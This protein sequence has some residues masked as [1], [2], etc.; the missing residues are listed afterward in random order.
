MGHHGCAQ[1]IIPTTV[2]DAA[3]VKFVSVGPYP[4]GKSQH[5][6][7]DAELVP[8][9]NE[10]ITDRRECYECSYIAIATK[11]IN[12][13]DVL[14]VHMEDVDGIEA[15]D[16]WNFDLSGY[17]ME[18]THTQDPVNGTVLS[19]VS[20]LARKLPPKQPTAMF[21]VEACPVLNDDQA[22]DPETPVA[23]HH[24]F[25]MPKPIY[26]KEQSVIGDFRMPSDPWFDAQQSG[27][28]V[29]MARETY[30]NDTLM[31]HSTFIAKSRPEPSPAAAKAAAAALA[32]AAVTKVAA[33]A[34][35]P[36]PVLIDS[37]EEAPAPPKKLAGPRTPSPEPRPA[38]KKA[39]VVRESRTPSP[40]L[41]VAA[42]KANP[43]PRELASKAN[44]LSKKQQLAAMA[45]ATAK[46][47]AGN[48]ERSYSSASSSSSAASS[49]S[50]S[51]SPLPPPPPQKPAGRA[52]AVAVVAPS[53]WRA[54]GTAPAMPPMAKGRG[55][56]AGKANR[57]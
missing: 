31:A 55:R 27:A 26:R 10:T 46:A 38:P 48:K 49:S 25:V 11:P 15:I 53:S 39:R 7:P 22:S 1:Y 45:E 19:P 5:V 3:N 37:D 42:S 8:P 44:P 33:P 20:V 13:G 30:N 9:N 51:P 24:R 35:A 12:K 52:K 40:D 2:K 47:L 36:S 23:K 17:Q 4:R 57:K 14:L 43:L 21:G 54:A 16:S 41:N 56:P 28:A 29:V 6:P 18:T 34:K 32:R 50:R